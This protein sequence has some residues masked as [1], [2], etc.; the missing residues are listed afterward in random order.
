MCTIMEEMWDFCVYQW[1][2]NFLMTRDPKYEDPVVKDPLKEAI[3][4]YVF[5]I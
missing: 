4:L 5:I 2:Y 1:I 3:Y